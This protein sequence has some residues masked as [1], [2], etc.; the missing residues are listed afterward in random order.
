V[1]PPLPP[2]TLAALAVVVT[3]AFTVETALGFGATVVAIALGSFVAPIELILPA[4]LPLNV[5]VSLYVTARYRRDVDRG[6]LLRRIVPWMGLG[7]PVGVLLF[8][9]L[10]SSRLQLAF[11]VFVIALSALELR[12]P[13]AAGGAATRPL[14]P[15][16]AAGLLF[17][18]GI[19]HGVFA[20]GGPLTVYVTGRALADK[21][22]FRATLSAL[23]L[24][25]N[26]ALLASY[27][28]GGQLGPGSA[29]LSA[30]L[31]APLGLGMALGEG[32]HR[33]V[34]E[35][36]FRTLVFTLLLVAGTLLAGRAL[37]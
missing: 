28:A 27:A 20:T 30:I 24:V 17:A 31:V 14:G 37:R 23:W 26:L 19:I 34:P 13:R 4:F 10:G 5:V 35:R 32:A 6:M 7:L 2:A 25:L 11:G 21:A 18:A 16:L 12:R 33:R 22:R 15:V 1:T 9:S 8:R 3:A 29:A 36:L